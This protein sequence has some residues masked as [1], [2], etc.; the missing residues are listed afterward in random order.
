M[1]KAKKPNFMM[2]TQR[3]LKKYQTL[4]NTTAT[5]VRTFFSMLMSY[6]QRDN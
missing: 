4:I 6:L 5:L 1:V 2:R 3:G